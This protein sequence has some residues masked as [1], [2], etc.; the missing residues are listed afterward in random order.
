MAAD[1]I[2]LIADGMIQAHLGGGEHRAL[3][4][5]ADVAG[6]RSPIPPPSAAP[7][8]RAMVLVHL[9]QA[10]QHAG[11]LAASAGWRPEGIGGAGASS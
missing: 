7:W 4:G 6:G 3:A 5:D 2:G 11:E 1:H 10:A 8:T 9:G